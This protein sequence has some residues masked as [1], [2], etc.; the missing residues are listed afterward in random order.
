MTAASAPG[1]MRQVREVSLILLATSIV[2][3][4]FIIVVD[5]YP[6]GSDEAEYDFTARR[7]ASGLGL[8][9]RGGALYV[10]THPPFYPIFIGGIYALG[11][12][13]AAVRWVQLALAL[14]TLVLVSLTARRVFGTAAARAALLAGGAYLPTAYYVTRLLSE[15]LFAF[16]LVVGVYLLITASARERRGWWLD[17]AAGVAFGV[18]GLTRGVALVAAL[19]VAFALLL[20]RGIPGGRRWVSAAAFA[21]GVAAAVLPWSVYVYGETGRPVLVDTKGPDILYLGNGPGTPMHHAWDMIDGSGGYFVPPEGIRAGSVYGRSQ[22]LGVAALKYMAAHPFQTSLRFVSKFADMWEAERLFIGA[23]REGFLLKAPKPWIYFYIAAEVAASA[24]ALA[25]FWFTI[26][27]TGKSFWRGLTLAVVLSTAVAYALTIAH[28]RYNY[29]LMVLGLPAVGY[30]FVDAL[31]RLR[32]RAIPGR[33]LVLAGVLV[34]ALLLIWAR[35]AWLFFA[36]G[37]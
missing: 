8:T 25:L 10:H 36:R 6:L 35:M 17:G 26:P 31:P 14:A 12:G 30:F 29:P 4:S 5:A 7:L 13:A 19:T 20:R 16:F 24:A 22:V 3:A 1:G 34:A 32:A 33:R 28:P 21:V 27:L 2:W 11:G 18:A 23:W 37:S 9:D 15:V